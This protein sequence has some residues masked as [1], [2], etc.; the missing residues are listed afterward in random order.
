MKKILALFLAMVLIAGSVTVSTWASFPSPVDASVSGNSLDLTVNG[1]NTAVTTFSAANVVPG[2]T[3]SGS[4]I[5]GNQ[6]TLDGKLS[7]K[8]SAINNTGASGNTEYEDGIGDLGAVAEMALY[9]DVD[10]SGTWNDGDICLKVD[11]TTCHY[12][13]APDYA[14]IDS[15][16]SIRWDTANV[17]PVAVAQDFVILWRIPASAG[18]NI[19]GEVVSFDI[20]FVLE[21]LIEE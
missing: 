12:L 10:R 13:D 16:D 11:G 6:G 1:G 5:L 21:P 14:S 2:S 9:L 4:T 20:E 19:Q 8:I 7:I 18:N 3:G 15:Y 17:L